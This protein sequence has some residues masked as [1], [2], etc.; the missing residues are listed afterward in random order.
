LRFGKLTMTDA[1]ME[2]I[3]ADPA[4]PFDFFPA[5]YTEQLVAGY[6]KNTRQ[7]GLKVYMPDFNDTRKTGALAEASPS[8]GSVPR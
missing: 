4:D 1:D 5:R 3:D 6:S 7:G 2:L 8:A